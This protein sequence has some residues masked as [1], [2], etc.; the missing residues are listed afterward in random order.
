MSAVRLPDST[1]DILDLRDHVR[2][3]NTFYF[4]EGLRRCRFQWSRLSLTGCDI[5]VVGDSIDEGT[6]ASSYFKRWVHQLKLR[7]K[8]KWNPLG[9][10]GKRIGGFGWFPVRIGDN[11][12]NGKSRTENTN[13]VNGA[14][15]T[16]DKNV[17]FG[18]DQGGSLSWAFYGEEFYNGAGTGPGTRSQYCLAGDSNYFVLTIDP[19]DPLADEKLSYMTSFEVVARRATDSGLIRIDVNEFA[20]GLPA[21]GAGLV[22]SKTLDTNGSSQ[23]GR[24]WGVQRD[25]DG[26]PFDP[27]KKYLVRITAPSAAD[28]R[29]MYFD[30]LILY[31]Y[32]ELRG[33]RVHNL[34]HAGTKTSS[35]NVSVSNVPQVGT[36]DTGQRQANVDQWTSTAQN[37]TVTEGASRCIVF[38]CNFITNDQSGTE[39]PS[40]PLADFISN[41]TAIV[42]ACTTGTHP[43][44]FGVIIPPIAAGGGGA[45]AI[46]FEQHKTWSPA[47][48]TMCSTVGNCSCLNF[49]VGMGSGTRTNTVEVW[50]MQ[51]DGLHL[52]DHG[53]YY[54]SEEVELFISP[55]RR[56]A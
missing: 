33:I 42:T 2:D 6:G 39:P 21:P 25:K 50:N 53:Q 48:M 12:R 26:N 17:T 55:L 5:C 7:L 45:E 37:N 15:W 9:P 44:A 38:L 24:H 18:G 36:I 29:K 41:Y 34:A 30:G 27:T 49:W 35:W 8:A 54:M 10:D 51:F 28:G 56:Y 31:R 14:G 19:T 22:L 43:A 3:E 20:D 4:P 23:Y 46:R 1:E 11:T 52:N 40:L 47:L 16:T 32:D 13:P